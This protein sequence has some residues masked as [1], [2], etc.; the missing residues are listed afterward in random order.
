M[1]T[2]RKNIVATLVF[3]YLMYKAYYG[4]GIDLR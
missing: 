4:L 3:R 2:V 1:A